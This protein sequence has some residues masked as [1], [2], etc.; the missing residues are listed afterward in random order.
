MTGSD[1]EDKG[2]VACAKSTEGSTVVVES[3]I[4]GYGCQQRYW[5][6]EHLEPP[7]V[8]ENVICNQSSSWCHCSSLVDVGL[9]G[10][11]T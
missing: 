11:E 1:A 5:A 9:T 3:T 10:L 4:E 7:R 8:A 2:K 6:E